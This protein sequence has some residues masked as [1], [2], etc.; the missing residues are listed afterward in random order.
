MIFTENAEN[1]ISWTD[2]LPL[3]QIDVANE[4]Q[5]LEHKAKNMF[6]GA[7]CLKSNIK[8]DTPTPVP[9]S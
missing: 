1:T 8:D 2:I 5:Q 7:I 9:K 6:K 3:I 4:A